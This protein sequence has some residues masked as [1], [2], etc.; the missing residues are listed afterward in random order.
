MAANSFHHQAM[1]KIGEGLCVM[2]RASDGIVE[3]MYMP[4]KRYVRA[5]QWHPE[6]LCMTD[7]DNRILFEDFVLAAKG[8]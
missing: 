2:A 1:K 5:Y 6:R 3:A 8:E 7:A 4:K